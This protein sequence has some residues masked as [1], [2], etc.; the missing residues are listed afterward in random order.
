MLESTHYMSC[1]R[2]LYHCSSIS[3]HMLVLTLK[4]ELTYGVIKPQVD[5]GWYNRV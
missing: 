4:V 2:L 5:E 1:P 3:L